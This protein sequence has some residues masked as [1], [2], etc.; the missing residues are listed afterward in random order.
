MRGAVVAVPAAGAGPAAQCTA[1]Q[2]A[3]RR[4]LDGN[5]DAEEHAGTS[6]PAQQ[7]QRGGAS[8]SS[9][10][11]GRRTTA[12]ARQPAG[13][14]R[15]Q[16]RP[17]GRLAC[18]KRH[19]RA[20][21]SRPPALV[22]S[23]TSYTYYDVDCWRGDCGRFTT[24]CGAGAIRPPSSPLAAASPPAAE[25]QHKQHSERAAPLRTGGRQAA[26][27]QPRRR[28]R[29]AGIIIAPTVPAAL[30]PV[31]RFRYARSDLLFATAATV[32]ASGATPSCSI[33]SMSCAAEGGRESRQEKSGASFH[34][35][36]GTNCGGEQGRQMM[37][38]ERTWH[39]LS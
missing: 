9:C 1:A 6:S 10:C 7:Q 27:Q 19:R 25:E 21:P 34:G 32:P 38:R 16:Q 14:R 11:S 4:A 26:A 37:T 2:Q 39:P 17:L 35:G 23:N 18:S 28:G 5:Q 3:R 24:Q 12:A 20:V 29:Q 33:R 8:T 22:H 30:Q 36:G 13:G 15:R 31:M